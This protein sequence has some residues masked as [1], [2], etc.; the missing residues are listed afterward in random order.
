VTSGLLDGMT[1][2]IIANDDNSN[3]QCA[4]DVPLPSL[5]AHGDALSIMKGCAKTLA[6]CTAYGNQT[7]FPGAPLVPTRVTQGS[8]LSGR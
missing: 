5:L 4:L 1:R 3:R 6:A 2:G 7:K 8:N